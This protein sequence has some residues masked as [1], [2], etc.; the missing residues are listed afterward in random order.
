[1]IG[2]IPEVPV[3]TIFESRRSLHDAGIHRGL[4]QGIGAG[5][6]SIVLSGGYIDDVDDDDTIIYTGEVAV[7]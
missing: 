2:E 3:G 4:Q 5:G 6:E 1:M 7:M